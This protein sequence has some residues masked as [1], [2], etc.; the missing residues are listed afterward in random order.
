VIVSR[1][2]VSLLRLEETMESG[3]IVGEKKETENRLSG[4]KRRTSKRKL[5]KGA[6]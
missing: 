4:E 3:G 6:Y 5:K 2:P 1:N